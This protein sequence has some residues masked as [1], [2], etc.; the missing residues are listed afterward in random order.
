MKYQILTNVGGH[1]HSQGGNLSDSHRKTEMHI[2][3]SKTSL[4]IQ[5]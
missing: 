5:L 4:L 3:Y 2:E 1:L